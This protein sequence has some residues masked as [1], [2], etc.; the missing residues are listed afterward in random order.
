MPDVS[1]IQLI[2]LLGYFVPAFI[3]FA[4]HHHN[5]WTIFALD[6]LTAWSGIGWIAAFVWA[7]TNPSRWQLVQ[8][9]GANIT[10]ARF[11]TQTGR[12]IKGYDAQTGQPIFEDEQPKPS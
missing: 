1:P 9:Q 4:R 12:P 11:D 3:A 10:P 5:K 6:L 2:I 7:L 8:P